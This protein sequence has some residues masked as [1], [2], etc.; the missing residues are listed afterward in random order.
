MDKARYVLNGL[1]CYLLIDVVVT[2][3]VATR[4]N[5]EEIRRLIGNCQA[6][7]FFQVC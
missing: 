6:V 2:Y 3:H 7:I 5:S 4:M 1:I